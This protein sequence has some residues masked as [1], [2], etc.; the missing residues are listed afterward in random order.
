MRQTILFL[1]HSVSLGGAERVAA[2]LANYWVGERF[3]VWVATVSSDEKDFYKFDPRI[4]RVGLDLA[5]PSKGYVSAILNNI[6]I[7]RSV[8]HLIKK[9]SP[10]VTIAL[11]TS[12]NVYLALSSWNLSGKRIGSEHNHPT[13]R[14][15]GSIW[16]LL[17]RWTYCRLDCLVALTESSALWLRQNTNSRNVRV[18]GNPIAWPIPSHEPVIKPDSVLLSTRKYALAVGRL[19][20]QKGFDLLITAFSRLTSQIPNWDLVI[21]G[22]GELQQSLQ[23][24]VSELKLENRIFIIGPVGN[25][26]DW[27]MAS[28]LYVLSSRF[29]GFGNTLAEAMSYGLP[30]ISFDCE[31]GPSDII[32]HDL[33]GLLIPAGDIEKLAEG[34]KTLMNDEGL[35]D[36]LAAQAIETRKRLS[37]ERVAHQWEAIFNDH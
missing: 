15:I 22:Y 36:R 26:G 10:D 13:M 1:I 27:F 37:V 32:H 19:V 6:K 9:I 14:R 33:D 20:E 5:K 4:K 11:M 16:E 21:I 7:L 8:R 28:D 12:A 23:E 25:L 30:V 18:I 34:L 3:D 35:R 29:E 2:N 24:Q 17:R 31:T